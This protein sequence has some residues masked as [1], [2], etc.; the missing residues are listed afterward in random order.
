MSTL[1]SHFIDFLKEVRLTP[2]QQDEAKSGHETLRDRLM[3]YDD[4]K[5]CIITTFLQGSYKRATAL[6]P[7][8]EQK[9]DIDIVVVTNLDQKDYPNPAVAINKFLPFV[10]KY[11]SGK[12][13]NTQG[14]SIGIEL[15]EVKI[16]PPVIIAREVNNLPSLPPLLR[17]TPETK[18]TI[19]CSL[20]TA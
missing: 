2:T 7:F 4:L 18:L 14:R 6:R 12:Y 15:S 19:A 10:E 11:Y 9:S 5:F 17:I 13:D 20:I 1:P 3:N 8:G 16:G